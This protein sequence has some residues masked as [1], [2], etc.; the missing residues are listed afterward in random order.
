MSTSNYCPECGSEKVY[1][2]HSQAF[3][4][5]SGEHYCHTVKCHDSYSPAGC[6]ECD[7]SGVRGDLKGD[8]HDNQ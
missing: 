8:D 2:T 7:W 5:N 6:C 4:V 1:S 3:M